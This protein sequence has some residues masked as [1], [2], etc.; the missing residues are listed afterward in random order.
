[1][2]QARV[3]RECDGVEREREVVAAPREDLAQ[4]VGDSLAVP[5]P[6]EGDDRAAPG[7]GVGL[8]GEER[9]ER[10]GV[11]AR[12]LDRRDGVPIR[13]RDVA[14]VGE[15]PELRSGAATQDGREV[16]LGTVF[17]LIGENS[18]AVAQ[19]SAARLKEVAKTL[20]PGVSV[21]P[22]Y[23]RT[24]LVDRTIATVEKN[25]VEGALLV[26]AVLFALLGNFRAALITAAV[27]PLAA[28]CSAA[29][30]VST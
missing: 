14:Q 30:S 5:D 28:A 20:P 9:L 1:M 11:A 4:Q 7:D 22:V 19:A 8:G 23:D 25:L 2:E 29:R 26:I 24:A 10:G 21:H 18:R 27:I 13:V 12:V 17:M 3:A 16:V 6:A 15:G